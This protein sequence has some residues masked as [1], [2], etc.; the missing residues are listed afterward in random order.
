MF[1]TAKALGGLSLQLCYFR[2]LGEFFA[3][4]WY[5]KSDSLLQ[6]MA[7]IQCQAGVTQ[8]ERLF[9]HALRENGAQRIKG[10]V[11]V[12]DS[13]EENIDMLAQ[14]AGKLGML[15]VPLFLFQERE[16]LRPERYLRASTVRGL[17]HSSMLPVQ[18]N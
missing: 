13:A 5:G 9:R 3:S 6:L 11:F 14:A 16:T 4:D 10:V 2:G 17:I 12:G 8:L 1:S 15:N 18:R 7:D